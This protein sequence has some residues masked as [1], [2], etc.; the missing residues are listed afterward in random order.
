MLQQRNQVRLNLKAIREQPQKT[1]QVRGGVKQVRP[2]SLR[3]ITADNLEELLHQDGSL[4]V[5]ALGEEVE[6]RL[7][8]FGVD[9]HVGIKVKLLGEQLHHAVVF[10]RDYFFLVV[11]D[12]SVEMLGQELTEFVEVLTRDVTHLGTG[13]RTVAQEAANGHLRFLAVLR[14]FLREVFHRL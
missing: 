4:H 14:K 6:Q 11:H 9:L 5:N 12:E 1:S 7:R 2:H 8:R 13:L 3:E 10:Q